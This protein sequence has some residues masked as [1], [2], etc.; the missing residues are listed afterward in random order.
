[1]QIAVHQIKSLA[2]EK[3]LHHIFV[4]KKFIS[5]ATNQE[6]NR[7]LWL[8]IGVLGHGCIFTIMTA[9]AIILTGNHI[10]FWPIAIFA[11]GMTL[12]TNLAAM[13]TKV[14][15]PVFFLSLLIDLGIIIACIASGFDV[16]AIY[17]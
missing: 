16:N 15:I 6:E 14:T 8:A 7:L 1:M 2:S 5:W 17:R 9:L 12:V 11:M 13:P 4:W 10:I 3:N